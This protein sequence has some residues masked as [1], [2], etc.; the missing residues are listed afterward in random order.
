MREKSSG[1]NGGAD[2]INNVES[3]KGKA[4]TYSK[5][6][7]LSVVMLKKIKNLLIILII[8]FF[9]W[10]IYFNTPNIS[11][12]YGTWISTEG[13]VLKITENTIYDLNVNEEKSYTILKKRYLNYNEENFCNR[14]KKC[15]EFVVK[16]DDNVY[17]I[18]FPYGKDVSFLIVYNDKGDETGRYNIVSR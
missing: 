6:T 4:R 7:G 13:K 5:H 16:A 9:C 3:L 10:R 18:V 17:I 12:M 14:E 15:N 2:V 11:I 1:H 8:M